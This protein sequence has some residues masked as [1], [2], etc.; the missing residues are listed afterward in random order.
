MEK[1]FDNKLKNDKLEKFKSILEEKSRRLKDD[2]LFRD[3]SKKWDYNENETNVLKY[4]VNLS[5]EDTKTIEEIHKEWRVFNKEVDEKTRETLLEVLEIANS[6]LR[7]SSSQLKKL[8]NRLKDCGVICSACQV[9]FSSAELQRNH[10]VSDWHRYNLKRKVVDLSPVTLEVFTQKVLAQQRKNQIAIEKENFS[11]ECGVCNKIY[12]SNNAYVNHLKSN[13]HKVAE[14]RSTTTTSISDTKTKDSLLKNTS[15]IN[16]DDDNNDSQKMPKKEQEIKVLTMEDETSTL[17]LVDKKIETSIRLGEMDC[18]F[19]AHKSDTFD[20]NIT[21]MAKVHSFF[22]PEV[23]YLVNIRGLIKYLGEKISVGN[24]CLYCNGRGKGFQSLEAVRKHMIDKGHTMIIY[25]QEDDIME[26]SDYYDFR[27]SYSDLDIDDDNDDEDELPK[28]NMIYQDKMELV[29]PSGARI[30]HRSLARYYKQ[31]LRNREGNNDVSIIKKLI[32]HYANSMGYSQQSGGVLI[33]HD[34][35]KNFKIL[36][37][38]KYQ[39][40]RRQQNFDTRIG[41]KA[42]KLQR[43]FRPQIM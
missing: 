33:T 23:E 31:N 28:R 35:E 42:N 14:T 17:L 30:G 34:G 36:Q 8:A 15:N 21:H 43:Y 32:T 22:I 41:V 12:Y 25:D 10:Y 1:S 6:A 24:V 38:N 39:D 5:L 13:K 16:V 9:G 11:V 2:F 19:C 40:K 27:S 4:F 7:A 3:I 26:I 18:L 37:R 29:L 20:D